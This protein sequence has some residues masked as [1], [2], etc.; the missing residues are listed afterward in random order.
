MAPARWRFVRSSGHT[1][2]ALRRLTLPTDPLRAH[3]L[4]PGP[5]LHRDGLR[6]RR[7]IAKAEQAREVIAFAEYWKRVAGADPGLL[8]FDS[9][10]TTYAVLDEL[11]ARLGSTA[12]RL[13]S[14]RRSNRA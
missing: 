7:D 14:S 9:K 2:G 12:N 5:R 11:A 3:L 13:I 1:W 4:R 8:V 10:L 6:Q